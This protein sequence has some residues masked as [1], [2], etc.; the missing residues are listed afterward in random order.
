MHAGRMSSVV[1]LLASLAALAAFQQAPLSL[2]GTVREAGTGRALAGVAVR[3]ADAG[4]DYA[5]IAVA[6]ADGRY[7]VAGLPPGRYEVSG[8]LDGYLDGRFG[9]SRVGAPGRLVDL[10][11]T[12]AV[13]DFSLWHGAVIT[14]TVYGSDGRPRSAI[15]VAPLKRD[16]EFGQPR[17]TPAGRPARTN[18]KGEYRIFGLV[19]G[20]YFV[21]ATPPIGGA[22]AYGTEADSFTYAPGVTDAGEAVAVD[23][24]GGTDTIVNVTLQRRAVHTVSGTI[25]PRLLNSGAPSLVEF[26]LL[27][28]RAVRIVAARKDGA[29]TVTGL[30]PGRYKVSVGALATRTVENAPFSS[31]VVEVLNADIT[32]LVLAP[33]SPVRVRGRIRVANSRG[34]T[35]EEIESVRISSVPAERDTQP[36]LPSAATVTPDS[37]FVLDVWPGQFVLRLATR[38]TGWVI[39]KVTQHGRD[40]TG[41][42][43]AVAGTDLTGIELHVTD[44][45]PRLRGT[46][47]RDAATTGDCAVVA[48]A[49]DELLWRTGAGMA[50][51]LV[52]ADGTFSI[53]SL[54]P[55]DYF[56]AAAASADTLE[57]P[58]LLKVFRATGTRVRLSEGAT[59]EVTVRC[60][61]PGG[62]ALSGQAQ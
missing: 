46:V 7:R 23:A 58:A 25:D 10:R 42:L 3:V 57:D 40:L 14:G 2:T 16:I 61:A 17:L 43:L 56:V 18:D 21:L 33:V 9:Q 47:S 50:Q 30:L 59:S 44:N 27:S 28:T 6:D 29:F 34:L 53:H 20:R 5:R 24:A 15:D 11:S 51:T 55:G 22:A 37:S 35:A 31:T 13:A 8:R 36:G 52:G 49:A 60:S 54:A 41:G 38:R 48:F 45:A 32:G 4:S 39:T 12:S 1:G 62:L 26:R 19:P